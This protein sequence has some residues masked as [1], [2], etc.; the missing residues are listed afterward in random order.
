MKVG[1]FAYKLVH[2]LCF[3]KVLLGKTIRYIY[4]KI[5]R[6]KYQDIPLTIFQSKNFGKEFKS[7]Q[8]QKVLDNKP[9]LIIIFF[10]VCNVF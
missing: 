4:K 2:K 1:F 10:F 9:L 3:S 7:W 8:K 5:G 6:V